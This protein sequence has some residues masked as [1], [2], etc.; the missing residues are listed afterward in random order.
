MPGI[1]QFFV[2]EQKSIFLA[3]YGRIADFI[4]VIRF[5]MR[6][7][8]YL[9]LF[10]LFAIT[11]SLTSC[12]DQKKF[13]Y[14]QK[15][16]NQ[17]DTIKMAQ[18]YVPKIQSGDILS[19]PISS[20]NPAASSFFNPFAPAVIS[21]PDQNTGSGSGTSSS[22]ATLP[23]MSPSVPSS[24]PTGY[25]VDQNGAVEIPL[26]GPVKVAGLT[27]VQARDTIKSKLTKFLKE[28]SVNVRLQ[29]YKISV[30]GEVMRP[31]IYVIPNEQ[32][33]LPEAISLAGDLTP[34]AKH[35]NILIVRDNDGKKEFGRVNLN[36]R[37]IFTSPYYY[38][39]SG[40]IVY[41]EQ[42]R[43]KAAQNDPTIRLLPVILTTVAA[44]VLLLYRTK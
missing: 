33:T 37:D 18:A 3:A 32:V 6:K 16:N 27:T 25:L 42:T 10:L 34:F 9:N 20:L 35:E 43:T 40:D 23:G 39:H 41:V 1:K 15:D 13:I 8:I 26:L 24:A 29:N 4:F 22:S 31:S 12:S 17:P 5:P 21:T 38:L 11:A 2:I 30:L 14:F 7:S 44:F 36:S 28:P 19:I